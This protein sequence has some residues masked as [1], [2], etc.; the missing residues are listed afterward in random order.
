MV[1]SVSS[2][3]PSM[4]LPSGEGKAIVRG[5]VGPD[6]KQATPYEVMMAMTGAMD[7]EQ[8]SQ[9]DYTMVLSNITAFLDSLSGSIATTGKEVAK[10]IEVSSYIGVALAVAT[11]AAGAFGGAAAMGIVDASGAT[12]VSSA[13]AGALGMVS[14]AYA[15]NKACAQNKLDVEENR[16]DS[17]QRAQ[18]TEVSGITNTSQTVQYIAETTSAIISNT[19]RRV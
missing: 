2:V 1:T 9:V 8:M 6:R 14:A 7:Q 15:L 10:D 13:V 19:W 11:L 3:N 16:S 18:S 4:T 5:G 17:W 12:V